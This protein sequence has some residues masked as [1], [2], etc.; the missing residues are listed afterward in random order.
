MQ[1]EDVPTN[2]LPNG[3]TGRHFKDLSLYSNTLSTAPP[4]VHAPF[5][6]LPTKCKVTSLFSFLKIIHRLIPIA[7]SN[8]QSI[9]KYKQQHLHIYMRVT[10]SILYLCIF[11]FKKNGASILCEKRVANKFSWKVRVIHP[12]R[13]CISSCWPQAA[14]TYLA[15]RAFIFVDC[16]D[17]L[18]LES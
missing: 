18:L 2:F 17:R 8:T 9:S 16:L 7:H 14:P 6:F 11:F 1:E 3:I 4:P 12:C 13:A 5:Q 15:P 10:V